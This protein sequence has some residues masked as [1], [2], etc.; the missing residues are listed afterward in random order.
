MPIAARERI[1]LDLQCLSD[2]T[3]RISQSAAQLNLIQH[4]TCTPTLTQPHDSHISLHTL[5]L[6]DAMGQLR[7][8][9]SEEVR[10]LSAHIGIAWRVQLKEERQR[11][12]HASR[13]GPKPSGTGAQ[14]RKA[15][16]G[17]KRAHTC[18]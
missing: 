16:Q 13:P 10:E 14:N 12:E 11:R 3:C 5:S 4:A 6:K 1:S 8:H 7:Q 9:T 15:C 17:K 18:R 2:S